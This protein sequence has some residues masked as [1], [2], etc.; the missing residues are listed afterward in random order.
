MLLV[1]IYFGCAIGAFAS[2]NHRFGDAAVFTL[3]TLA[4]VPGLVQRRARSW[5]AWLVGLAIGLLLI[6][7][8]ADRLALELIPVLVNAALCAAFAH[9]LSAG[10]EALI[11]R[12]IV[13]LEGPARLAL[14]GVASYARRLTVA[15]ALLLGV[16]AVLLLVVVFCRV[17]NGELAQL[18]I[19]P[20]IAL[21]SK[22]FEVY[23]HVGCYLVVIAFM[24]FEYGFRRWHLRDVPHL[25]LGT[26]LIRLAQ[27]WP[28]LVRG[29]SVSP[30]RGRT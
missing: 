25:S 23:L 21:A 14:P 17:P 16:Q 2:G 24:L 7:S 3:F 30:T 8:G 4:L 27:R 13:A 20:P 15:W 12:A 1:L 28:A 6:E 26:F 22:A 11:A 19:T 5:V 18:G 10:R 9:S 29:N